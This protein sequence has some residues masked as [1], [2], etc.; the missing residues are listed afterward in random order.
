MTPLP[1][2]PN[3]VALLG[4]KGEILEIASNIG[5]DFQLKLVKTRSE[6]NDEAANKP[7]DTSRPLPEE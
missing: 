4:T 6:F 1:Q 2:N 5:P 3:A 7:F